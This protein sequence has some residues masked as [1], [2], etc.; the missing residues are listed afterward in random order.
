[1][2]SKPKTAFA[3]YEIDSISV[4]TL[5]S[6]GFDI[7]SYEK[8]EIPS[9]QLTYFLEYDLG[10][11]E[12]FRCR[13]NN[14]SFEAT[15]MKYPSNPQGSFY[16][17]Q[18]KDTSNGKHYKVDI[19]LFSSHTEFLRI[20][21]LGMDFIL[22]EKFGKYKTIPYELAKKGYQVKRIRWNFNQLN[23]SEQTLALTK[24]DDSR[25]LYLFLTKGEEQME[26]E[27][28]EFDTSGK[29]HQAK[30][31]VIYKFTRGATDRWFIE[32]LLKCVEFAFIHLSGR[33]FGYWESG[34]FF[35]GVELL[36]Y[37]EG[38]TAT[39][40]FRSRFMFDSALMKSNLYE[41]PE[42]DIMLWYTFRC[43]DAERILKYTG[44]PMGGKDFN[45]I[46]ECHTIRLT[47][48]KRKD[49]TSCY[50][51][52][53]SEYI[54]H[55]EKNDESKVLEGIGAISVLGSYS[56]LHKQ[57]VAY[58]SNQIEKNDLSCGMTDLMD[59]KSD[60]DA[61]SKIVNNYVDNSDDEEPDSIWSLNER[62][63]RLNKW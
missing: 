16:V 37:W 22:D 49:V 21:D 52:I 7:A 3:G 40:E 58:V 1:M 61:V 60:G 31:S 25:P 14:W 55:F 11:S 19:N 15:Y 38:A 23:P 51:T 26:I 42:I 13:Y 47:F 63:T 59:I 41:G 39:E 35:T 50:L 46:Y 18:I 12:N 36:H 27:I 24:L 28:S 4:Q 44:K 33:H 20:L 9:G 5:N 56:A 43:N 30:P 54:D 48:D 62:L 6:L 17:K 34:Q 57:V 8:N 32:E 45:W 2:D 53:V 10:P 29:D